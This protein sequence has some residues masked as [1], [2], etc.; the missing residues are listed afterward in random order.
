MKN[1][2]FLYI[3]ILIGIFSSAAAAQQIPPLPQ[4]PWMI[5]NQPPVQPVPL[6]PKAEKDSEDVIS[7]LIEKLAETA[8]RAATA[9]AGW[10]KLPARAEMLASRAPATFFLPR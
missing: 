4:V 7:P 1:N 2:R 10:K 5:P 6:Q 3:A 9:K 8:P